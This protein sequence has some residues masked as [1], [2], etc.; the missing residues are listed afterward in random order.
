MNMFRKVL[1]VTALVLPP[2]V[3][4]APDWVQ[5]ADASFGSTFLDRSSIASMGKALTV[6]VLRS[7]DEVVS[8]GTDPETGAVL[9]PHR[10]VKVQYLA[11]CAMRKVALDAW[12]LYSGNLGDGKVVWMDQH[13]GPAAYADP[14]S[15]EER[16]ALAAACA[17]EAAMRQ[18]PPKFVAV[19]K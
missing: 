13:S 2:A 17:T 11:D 1:L 4:A 18:Q 16:Y 9:Y 10:S 6:Q 19:T 15:R 3:Q 12:V 5:M 7:Y 8:F 14:A